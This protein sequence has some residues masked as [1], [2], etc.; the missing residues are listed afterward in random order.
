MFVYLSVT[1]RRMELPTAVSV[2]LGPDA[3]GD[4]TFL[5]AAGATV[6]RLR[7]ADVACYTFDDLGELIE[8]AD[9]TVRAAG[10]PLEVQFGRAVSSTECA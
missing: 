9:D 6:A 10:V 8:T 2:S 7:C 4:V 1:G 3:A 5:D